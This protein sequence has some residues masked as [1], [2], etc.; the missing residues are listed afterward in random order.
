MKA[1]LKEASGN[2][3]IWAAAVLVLRG[4][5]MGFLP[6]TDTTEAR[7]GLIAKEIVQ[8]GDWVIPHVWF[9][10]QH[11]PFLGK[12]PLFFWG[13]AGCMKLF[14]INEFSARLPSLLAFALTLV[15]MAVILRRYLSSRAAATAVY[16]GITCVVLLAACGLVI[17]DMLLTFAVTGAVLGFYAFCQEQDKQRRKA[18]SVWTAGMLGIGFMTKGPIVLVMVGLPVLIWSL[19]FRRWQDLRTQQ[20]YLGIT[21][22]GLMVA[23]WFIAAELRS[24]GFL[25]Y[26]FINENL[27]RFVVH[28]YGDRYGNGHIYPR[29]T[30][31]L[32]MLL[33]AAPWSIVGPIQFF[34]NRKKVVPLAL[35]RKDPFL[36]YFL[37]VVVVDTLFLVLA[38]QLLVT[39]LFP[40][41]PAYLVF[42]AM[43]RE[44]VPQLS[45]FDE[46]KISSAGVALVAGVAVVGMLAVPYSMGCSTKSILG[47]AQA[48]KKAG[49][50]IYFVRRVPFSAY[51][52]APADV[53]PHPD[54]SVE[55]SLKAVLERK[56]PVL[57]VADEKYFRHLK[58][59]VSAD[60]ILQ[61]SQNGDYVLAQIEANPEITAHQQHAGVTIQ[62]NP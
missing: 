35:L 1:F 45:F 13:A 62:T 48:Y 12:P 14:G 24:P 40:L 38:R 30:A 31:V 51:Y 4:V 57:V 46:R 3:Y 2:V 56:D 61:L 29:G 10:G 60:K 34:K 32:M 20:W 39:Y 15:I 42:L 47:K 37:L 43:L 21:L 54:E 5:L 19:L 22:F 52:Y 59:L 53:L 17:V 41:V 23:P 9:D 49:E 44:R 50:K 6:L 11:V 25:R 7:Y 27:L 33:A 36:M 28:E 55:D 58:T 16:L 26:F 18:W 8:S